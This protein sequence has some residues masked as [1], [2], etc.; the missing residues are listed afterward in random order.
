LS[1]DTANLSAL[2]SQLANLEPSEKIDLKEETLEKRDQLLKAY[3]L[4]QKRI[5]ITLQ[6]ETGPQT[7]SLLLGEKHPVGDAYFAGIS[8]NG[9]LNS[10]TVFL[11][12][13]SADG[14]FKKD[15]NHW[16]D[17][18]ILQLASPEVKEFILETSQEKIEGKRNQ[19]HWVLKELKSGQ[20]VTGDSEAID[21]LLT[22]VG[23]LNAKTFLAETKPEAETARAHLQGQ[24]VV[25][26][27]LKTSGTSE[28]SP[29]KEMI[30]QTW[31]TKKG[32]APFYAAVTTFD[33]LYE[34]DSGL[35]SRLLKSFRDLRLTK[36]FTASERLDVKKIR[37]EGGEWPSAITLIQD[38]EEWKLSES[39]LPFDSKKI[40]KWFDQLG[41]NRI[42][43]FLSGKKIPVGSST[44]IRV[45]FLGEKDVPIRQYLFWKDKP[46]LMLLA[47][48]LKKENNQEAYMIDASLLENFPFSPASIAPSPPTTPQVEKK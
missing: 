10:D 11:L 4:G 37:I 27:T 13:E 47:Q 16:R 19:T 8:E 14:P 15:T 5:D 12:P 29:T 28:K 23:H 40:Q 48:D 3:A 6:D 46:G 34:L 43:E 39:A 32:S 26:I 9:K 35:K 25:K 33:P 24:P 2:L 45:E 44:G 30:V 18:K 42:R 20:T 31:E 17:K 41:G 21:N 36:L 7:L 1:A 38:K 22:A